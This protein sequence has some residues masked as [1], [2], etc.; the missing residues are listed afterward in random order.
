M[1]VTLTP[2]DARDTTYGPYTGVIQAGYF[3]HT[4]LVLAYLDGT[5]TAVPLEKPHDDRYH[6]HTAMEAE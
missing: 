2:L 6:F 4:K 1:V 3:P 5:K